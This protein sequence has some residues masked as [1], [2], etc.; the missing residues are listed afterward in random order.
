MTGYMKLT[1]STLTRVDAVTGEQL[2]AGL[3]FANEAMSV[4]DEDG[5]AAPLA[6]GQAPNGQDKSAYAVT[7][8][9]VGP[10]DFFTNTT[11]D[12][13]AKQNTYY[14]NATA[15]DLEE[16]VNKARLL[17]ESGHG[18]ITV[19]ILPADTTNILHGTLHRWEY[20][21]GALTELNG[22]LDKT[23]LLLPRVLYGEDNPLQV[24]CPGGLV[25]KIT[26]Q[27]GTNAVVHEDRTHSVKIRA[28][29]FITD[30]PSAEWVDRPEELYKV[31]S[32]AHFSG[33]VCAAT[34]FMDY[35]AQSGESLLVLVEDQG[36][37]EVSPDES[38]APTVK[39]VVP[40]SEL[41]SM[42]AT[43][44]ISSASPHNIVTPHDNCTFRYDQFGG[45]AVVQPPQLVTLD[46]GIAMIVLAEGL[47]NNLN[48]PVVQQL[49][50]DG[51]D[52]EISTVAYLATN[53]PEFLTGVATY[54]DPAQNPDVCTLTALVLTSN[55][56]ELKV[57]TY[58]IR[59]AVDGSLTVDP[60]PVLELWADWK[61]ANAGK[62][63]THK[64]LN[65][66]GVVRAAVAQDA[67]PVYLLLRND[68][69][70]LVGTDAGLLVPQ[71]VKP[72]F[73]QGLCVGSGTESTGTESGALTV[74]GGV[75][76]TGDIHC[77]S[78]HCQSDSRLKQAIVGLARTNCLS[79]VRQLNPVSWRWRSNGAIDTGFIA[80]DVARILPDSV[81]TDESSG[82]LTLNYNTLFT[83]VTG[84]VQELAQE[85]EEMKAKRQRVST[86]DEAMMKL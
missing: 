2:G 36:L 50:L 72:T 9:D 31:E 37:Y 64:H 57:G 12:G 14:A 59:A 13:T 53:E 11:I 16:A 45:A 41:N 38:N 85:V 55:V 69:L 20:S 74:Q 84:A 81:R 30:G 61:A 34:K 49:F 58:T 3:S 66:R 62:L 67:R 40:S 21:D 78:C 23:E 25:Y 60:N 77:Q 1:K 24:V 42:N 52:D 65:Q 56:D 86:H 48:Q 7:W 22:T 17:A 32:A 19:L 29:L 79:I 4:K 28:H 43:V 51:N 71:H 82:T 70:V 35:V 10:S 76:V 44:Q 26:G 15:Q 46:T 63:Q 68:E 39:L 73:N 83:H 75:G 5:V 47:V 8:A 27:I 18:R 80:Q 54:D 6:V 33:S